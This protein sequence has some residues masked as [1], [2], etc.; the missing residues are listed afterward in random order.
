MRPIVEATVADE[1]GPMLATFFN[2]PWL[3]RRYSPGT[4]LVLHG[5]CEARNR[6]RVASHARTD[7]TT[8]GGEDVS[9]YAATEGITSTQLLALMREARPAICEL[10]EPLPARLRARER[11]A[12][13]C[14]GDR[15]D[16]T[17]G[18]AMSS[19]QPGGGSPSRSCCCS[20][21]RCCCGA[22]GEVGQHMRSR[23]TRR[24]R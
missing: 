19:R 8:E 10:I 23:W 16:C 14:R 1:T 6:F 5:K 24:R 7:E 12:R 11:A 18:R 13:A 20:S 3:A 21:S 17:S 9:H 22:R 2:Q 4:R 15:S